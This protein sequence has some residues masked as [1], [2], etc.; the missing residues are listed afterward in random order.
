MSFV[1][2][3]AMVSLIAFVFATVIVRPLYHLLYPSTPTPTVKQAFLQT[4][5]C[6]VLTYPP[7]VL[8]TALI[9]VLLWWPLNTVAGRWLPRWVTVPRWIVPLAI[10][11]IVYI[12]MT[13]IVSIKY[14]RTELIRSRGLPRF[15]GE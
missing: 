3:S 9:Y 8:Y 2:S 15:G 13:C 11:G 6:V 10:F 12:I 1:L 4:A 14:L 5:S 7:S